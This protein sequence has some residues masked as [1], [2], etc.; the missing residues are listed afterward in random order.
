MKKRFFSFAFIAGL[1]VTTISTSVA[2]ESAE[3]V[4]EGLEVTSE[5]DTGATVAAE[6]SST[7]FPILN[8]LVEDFFAEYDLAVELGGNGTGAGFSALIQGD[9][10]IATASRAIKDEEIEDL[11][12]NEINWE[13]YLVATDGLTVAVNQSIDFV[14]YLTF[15][16]LK[17]IYSG[18]VSN[19][20]EVRDEFPDQDIQV[21]GPTQDHGTHAFFAETIL[22]DDA[23]IG[24]NVQLIQDTNEVVRSVV[25]DEYA[26][27]F[28]G[29]NFYMENQDALTALP[30]QGDDMDEAAEPTFENV[31]DFTY[32]LSRP[33][34]VYTD[35]DALAESESAHAF[36]E[37]VIINSQEAAEAVGYVP[38]DAAAVLEQYN[39]LPNV[40]AVEY[41][42]EE[43][44]EE[45]DT[46]V[47]T[48]E[49][50]TEEDTDEDVDSEEDTEEDTDT[51]EED[52]EDAE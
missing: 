5:V 43:G 40:E 51:D 7:V 20:N 13:E 22:G 48:E 34:Y 26:I 6:G 41:D 28:F 38:L 33:L 16:E 27:G 23:E 4:L 21:Y 25:N 30:I 36:M 11:E 44:T 15:D 24:D 2:A 37:Y 3:D 50:E 47:E 29:Y 10:D 18:E 19:W 1:A 14:D 39:K 17:A 8:V 52:E 45:E 49:E 46:D 9:V 31:M 42:A 35:Q 32:P 12:E